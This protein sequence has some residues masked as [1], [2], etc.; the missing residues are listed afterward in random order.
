VPVPGWTGEYE[1]TG[2]VPFSRL[3][4]TTNPP[5]GFIV[6]A[7]NKPIGDEYPYPIGSNYAAPYR[8]TRIIEMLKSR[9]KHSSDD[10]A[11]MQADV[12]AIHARE[13]LPL[14]FATKPSNEQEKRALE[15]L[16]T[17]DLRMTEESSAAAVFEAW[18][19]ALG[20]R[21][22]AD[23]LGDALW[24]T[25]STN[26]YMVGMAL[27]QAL[28]NNSAWCDDVRTRGVETCGDTIAAALMDG[29]TR[30]TQ[31]QG[32]ADLLSWRWRAVHLALF[33]HSPFDKNEHLQ[34]MFSRKISHGGDKHTVNV[35]ST[36][37][38]ETYDQLHGAIYRQI[39]DFSDA[40]KSRFIVTPG[41]SGDPR[42]TH[43]DDLLPHWQSGEYAPIL[44]DRVAIEAEAVDR[45][46]LAP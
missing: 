4:Q 42:S 36:F 12:M 45:T 2:Y 10:M 43:Y 35:G 7:N 39:T 41:Q 9:G 34:S 27:P 24:N 44:N 19:T 17:W 33:P 18:Y 31:A 21:I 30:M 1:W 14:L 5:E 40:S 3:P 38:W 23:E 16:R 11:T 25:Y 6:T 13:L 46:T 15:L 20:R 22:F 37:L 29:L 26:I 28:R 32:S 8:A